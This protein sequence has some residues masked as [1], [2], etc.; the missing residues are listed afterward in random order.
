MKRFVWLL[1][2]LLNCLTSANGVKSQYQ[3]TIRLH[4]ERIVK[5]DSTQEEINS[6][7]VADLRKTYSIDQLELESN[8]QQNRLLRL[9]FIVILVLIIIS[10]GCFLYLK[11][12][13]HRLRRSQK[14]LQE[15]KDA[16]E[17]SLRNKSLLLSNMSHEIRTP[18]NALSG[19]SE[20][21]TAQDVDD[22]TRTFCN[23]II[24]QNSALLL[25]LVND[26][27]D[28][29]CLDPNNLQFQIK[30]IEATA[31]CQ[32]V[33]STLNGIK[34]TQA[35]IRFETSLPTLK[36]ETD[37]VRL[38]QVL[39]NLLINATKFTPAGT[40]T[41]RLEEQEKGM[42]LFSVT[43]TGCGIRSEQQAR[44]FD[45]FEKL[46][47][48]VQGTGLGLSICQLIVRRLGGETWVDPHY[49]TGAR[50]VFT[51]PCRQEEQV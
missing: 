32:S 15:A 2:L 28:I 31:L 12:Q 45:R 13:T 35:D 34:Q 9:T 29:S 40:I 19:F 27:I 17:E 4:R 43:D 3:E 51:H 42:A 38:Q 36:I 8:I 1:L 5:A 22:A 26:V 47:E 46:D 37:A 25:N 48:K 39:I 44:L 20:V 21:L 49:T 18:L 41:L 10:V 23:E 50:F 16:L 7:Q 6:R 30:T 33:A 24:Q 11:R 14:L